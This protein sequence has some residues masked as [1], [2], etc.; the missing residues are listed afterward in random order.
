MNQGCNGNEF[1][2]SKIAN[3]WLKV[4]GVPLHP[5]YECEVFGNIRFGNDC[6]LSHLTAVNIAVFM[7]CN[8][9]VVFSQFF[10]SCSGENIAF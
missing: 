6:A 10:S 1:S 3:F 5:W 7:C 9:N 4:I 2:I 8:K